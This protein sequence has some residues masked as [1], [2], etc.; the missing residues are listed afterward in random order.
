MYNGKDLEVKKELVTAICKELT[1]HFGE[2]VG[3]YG[4]KIAYTYE[5]G[6]GA[7]LMY[8]P[9]ENLKKLAA[10]EIPENVS[11]GTVYQA[12][13]RE[14]ALRFKP[15]SDHNKNN[16]SLV[17]RHDRYLH[18]FRGYRFQVSGSVD[19][20]GDH[21]GSSY[22]TDFMTTSVY[23]AKVLSKGLV[24]YML[25]WATYIDAGFQFRN[26]QEC[27]K[28]DVNTLEKFLH[29]SMEYWGCSFDY[30]WSDVATFLEYGT[31]PIDVC[32]RKVYQITD[33]GR[34][35]A[36]YLAIGKKTIQVQTA[37]STITLTLPELITGSGYDPD[38]MDDMDDLVS[39]KH[40]LESNHYL[41]MLVVML[42][43][44]SGI[45]ISFINWYALS[46]S[47]S[48]KWMRPINSPNVTN[49][50]NLNAIYGVEPDEY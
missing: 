37:D 38:D 11:F 32:N 9:V 39:E 28:A 29:E 46:G 4:H 3:R 10:F 44:L 22:R 40:V 43:K 48:I 31:T 42:L 30:H 5:D 16:P 47:K 15:Y 25:W 33:D 23:D 24:G 20:D 36:A 27:F 41:E 2:D 8:L 35:V 14:G 19:G 18:M 21:G 1:A 50:E 12:W 26:F 34:H 45:H 17:L 7:G 13:G 49:V 6:F